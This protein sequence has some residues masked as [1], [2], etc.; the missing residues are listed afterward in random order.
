MVLLFRTEKQIDNML[1]D[2]TFGNKKIHKKFMGKY[3]D[4][5]RNNDPN[6]TNQL[7]EDLSLTPRPKREATGHH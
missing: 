7:L 2:S 5:I 6:K 4:L 3:K 1:P